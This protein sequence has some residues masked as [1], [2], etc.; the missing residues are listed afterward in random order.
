M[1]NQ[2]KDKQRLNIQELRDNIKKANTTY[3][4]QVAEQNSGHR[5]RK[6]F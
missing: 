5:H 4:S 3:A 1:C 2:N 6:Y